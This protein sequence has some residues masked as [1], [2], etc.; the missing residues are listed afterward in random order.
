MVS[1]VNPFAFASQKVGTLIDDNNFLAWKQHVLLVVKT[2][3]LLRYLDGIV[4]VP[5]STVAD[6]DGSLVEI[7]IFVQYEQQD[8]AISAWLLSTVS[9]SLH[10][11]SIGDS[12]FASMLWSTLNRIF[13]SQSI[14]KAKRHRSLL[15]N[16]RKNDMSMSDYLAGIK[17]FCDCLAGCGQKVFQEEQQSA[18]LNG[19]PPEYDH[20]VSIITT[21]QTPFDLQGIA[22]ALLDAEAC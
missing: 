1:K 11:R 3:R 6:D 9:P 10:N 2:H 7:P 21:S 15:H 16:Y 22:T 12:S 14:T 19:L 18:I 8:A 20:V 17:H 5:S 4:V 13:G